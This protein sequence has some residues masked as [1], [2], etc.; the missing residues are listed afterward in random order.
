MKKRVALA[1]D[2]IKDICTKKF[3]KRLNAG[4]AV[5]RIEKRI[6][7]KVVITPV[8]KGDEKC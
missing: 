5:R 1:N 2:N 4:R 3:R 6:R 8:R 7:K